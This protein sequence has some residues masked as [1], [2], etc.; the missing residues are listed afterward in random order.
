M[1]GM[2]WPQQLS[3]QMPP[4]ELIYPWPQL[5]SRDDD[6]ALA[7]NPTMATATTKGGV[8][9]VGDALFAFAALDTTA[10]TLAPWGIRCPTLIC[11]SRESQFGQKEI[12]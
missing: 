1:Q 2:T 5:P 4:Q 8:F 9:D 11:Q 3:K 12:G 10:T 6:A 7:A